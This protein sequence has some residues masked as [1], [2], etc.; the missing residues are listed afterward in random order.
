[1]VSRR[2]LL[3]NAAIAAPLGALAACTTSTVNGVSTVT[4]NVAAVDKWA[5]AFENAATL[6]AGLPGIPVAASAAIN[7]VNAAVVADLAAFNAA[8]G[9]QVTLT[10]NGTSI[11]KAITSLLADGNVLLT[12]ARGA[13]TGVPTQYAQIAQEYINALAT[14][15]SIFE[16]AVGSV[17]AKL[18]TTS[19]TEQQALNALKV[20]N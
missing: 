16:A 18:S 2:N 19:M 14:I 8:A 12:D 1:M 3:R 13:I 20:A 15:V 5:T 6:I 7:V 11:P 4:L 9:S 10:F 17:S